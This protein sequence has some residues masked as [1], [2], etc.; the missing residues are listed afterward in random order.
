[1]NRRSTKAQNTALGALVMLGA[2]IGL[3]I[4]AVG[5]AGDAVGWP[6]LLGGAFA[7]LL[8]IH[9]YRRAQASATE[10]ERIRGIEARR[11]ELLGKYGDSD[12][13]EQIMSGLYWQ[14][15]SAE[16]LRD[17]LG[18][19]ADIDERVLKKTLRQTWKYQPTGRNRYALRIT[20]ENGTVVGWDHKS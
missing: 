3:P 8:A 7:V 12:I 10:A 15:Q 19:P 17:S 4:Y 5:K 18:H 1:M 11:A 2:I 20:L 6:I 14:G 9:F 13:V 16:Q